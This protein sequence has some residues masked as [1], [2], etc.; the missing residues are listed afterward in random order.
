M[1]RNNLREHLTWLI[2]SNPSNPPP[3]GS[4]T[5]NSLPP[6]ILPDGNSERLLSVTELLHR[7]GCS[8]N[9][10]PRP[11]EQES[12]S[13]NQRSFTS[14]VPVFP[15]DQNMARLQSGP[16]SSNKPRLLSQPILD[17]LQTPKAFQSLDPHTSRR[18]QFN[19]PNEQSTCGTF[20]PIQAL[21]RPR[22][23]I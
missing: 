16:R 9:G 20:I 21:G 3:Q 15:T 14:Q 17:P 2:A 22:L 12:Y 23:M 4:H 8:N 19:A 18:N 5:E 11:G 6:L 10:G 1:T 7:G 13:E